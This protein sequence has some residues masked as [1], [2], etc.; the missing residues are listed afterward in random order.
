MAIEEPLPQRHE[1]LGGDV[2][3]SHCE[4]VPGLAS[5]GIL[6]L[7]FSIHFP[8]CVPLSDK[9][10]GVLAKSEEL[11]EAEYPGAA[12]IS[13]RVLPLKPYFLPF[14][15]QSGFEGPSGLKH[16]PEIE[17]FFLMHLVLFIIYLRLLGLQ[18]EFLAVKA[19]DCCE[20]LGQAL[21]FIA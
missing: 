19:S 2:K 15:R 18:L 11:V 13:G 6:I 20:S 5:V 4:K 9:C 21:L 14:F 16:V 1:K 3:P 10:V 17:K 7:T 8:H 12:E